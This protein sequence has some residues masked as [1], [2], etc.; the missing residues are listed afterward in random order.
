[1]KILAE[2]LSWVFLPLLMPVYGLL[3]AMYVPSNQDYL[4]NEDSLFFLRDEAKLAILY[5]FIIFSV[6]APGLAFVLL[7][8]WKIITTIDME[9]QRE[10]NIPMFIM[11]TFCLILYFLFLVKAQ[12]NILPKYI[13]ALPLSGVFVTVIYTYINRW[14]KISLHGGGAG[15]LTGFLFAYAIEQAEFRFWILIFAI[16]ASGLTIGARLYLKKHTQTE[17]YTGWSLAVLMTFLVN[18]LYPIG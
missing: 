13:Y 8:K 18:Y 4:F 10:R 15:I 2:V 14:I 9:N 6:I 5:M 1:M 17:V 16:V 3:L 12:N 11:L 7:H